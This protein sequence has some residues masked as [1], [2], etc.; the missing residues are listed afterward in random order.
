MKKASNIKENTYLMPQNM[1]IKFMRLISD[2][3][4]GEAYY[5]VH[6]VGDH[7]IHVDSRIS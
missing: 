5:R 6:F 3:N 2:N 7:L 1:T 4:W